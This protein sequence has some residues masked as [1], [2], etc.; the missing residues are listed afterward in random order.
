MH[1][2]N[3]LVEA[4]MQRQEDQ[5]QEDDAVT[6][7]IER[8]EDEAQDQ[9]CLEMLLR[10]MEFWQVNYS[11]EVN[12]LEPERTS[13]ISRWQSRPTFRAKVR[14]FIS[15]AP[16]IKLTPHQARSLKKFVIQFLED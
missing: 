7:E 5:Q 12:I 15:R 1:H 16:D 4:H 3:Q 2:W 6:E 9:E 13:I 10:I 8:E 11:D 14:K